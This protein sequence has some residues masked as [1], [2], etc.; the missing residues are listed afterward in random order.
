MVGNC[1]LQLLCPL[2]LGGRDEIQRP[3]GS[4]SSVMLLLTITFFLDIFVLVF[5][6]DLL[7]MNY[8]N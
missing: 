1:G 2:C 5:T 4:V 6:T 8:L 7:Y 3:S